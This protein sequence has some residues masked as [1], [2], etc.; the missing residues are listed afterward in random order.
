MIRMGLKAAS[1]VLIAILSISTLTYA[2]V[3]AEEPVKIKWHS[4]HVDD[5]GLVHIKGIV[6]NSGI[7][8]VGFIRVTAELT[9]KQGK[10]L[11]T[12]DTIA[13]F[14]TVLPGYVT[15]FD[16][17]IS[18]RSVGERLASYTIN[19]S[20]NIV[21]AKPEKFE[22]S[23]ISAF[24]VT[25]M[26]PTTYQSRNPHGAHHNYDTDEPHAHSE[27]SG[28]VTNASELTTKSIKA[29]A[30]WYDKQGKFHGFDWQTISKKLAPGED[31]R[32]VFMTH[33]KGMG[34]YSI[35]AESD[36]Y[37]AMLKENGR[38]LIPLY[39][40]SK[41]Y[42]STKLV[43]AISISEIKMIDENNQILS[44]VEA[45]QAVLLQSVMKSN[46]NTKQKFISIYQIKDSSDTT[47]MLF[48]LSTQIPAKESIDAA[49][50]WI[51]DNKGT[52][53][54]QIFLWESLSNPI[55]V[56][57]FSESLITVSA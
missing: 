49:I 7:M 18:D 47:V 4:K 20:W 45:G 34:Y 29:A 36:D 39:E 12:Y 11:P 55:P 8:P 40:A 19:I 9:D 26:D 54:L 14:R 41:P 51:P 15:P 23:G 46:L 25:H 24:T 48:W 13:L 57:E 35:I 16:I 22:F 56:G 42:M 37:L 2:N 38:T 44:N 5:S 27:A 17:P 53:T 32:F 10:P 43:N 33:P 50:S 21:S 3:F 52:Y 1:F 28:Y 6:E 31:A 30:I